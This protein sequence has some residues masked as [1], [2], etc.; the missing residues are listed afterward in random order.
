M[1]NSALSN[2]LKNVVS[3]IQFDLLLKF[4]TVE[5]NSSCMLRNVCVCLCI[6]RKLFAIME[7]KKNSKEKEEKKNS[8]EKM[9]KNTKEKKEEK[10]QTQMRN[11]LCPT[12]VVWT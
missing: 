5:K 7:E 2:H 6:V 1:R 4:K 11:D 12:A 10:K 9:K 8:K 3:S